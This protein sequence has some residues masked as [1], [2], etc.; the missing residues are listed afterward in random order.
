M[1]HFKTNFTLLM[2]FSM[3]CVQPFLAQ[4]P[5]PPEYLIVTTGHWDLDYEEGSVDDIKALELEWFEKVTMKNEYFINTNFLNHYFTADNSEV[6][7]VTVYNTWED[8][9]KAT[10]RT[11]ELVEAAW[12]DE[13][14]REEYF[15]KRNAY[16]EDRHSDEIYH[17]LPNAK[18][19]ESVEGEE[20]ESMVY[21]VRQSN[22]AWPDD[23]KEE[24][25]K[26]LRKEYVENVV[27][28][29]P[30][31]KAYYNYRHA[32]GADNRQFTEVTVVSSLAHIE[33]GFDETEKLIEAHWP[34]EAERKAFFKKYDRYFSGWHGDYIYR[35]MPELMK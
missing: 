29:N 9:E 10:K 23:G 19:M 28:K 2:L 21:Y 13:T 25:F 31:V 4:E 11:E 16:Y 3:F 1:K 34:V 27:H 33:S 15:K 26:A 12:P 6:L 22:I 8:I 7:F 14:L 18:F 35:N 5:A 20:P 24:E 17:I 32:W 30:N